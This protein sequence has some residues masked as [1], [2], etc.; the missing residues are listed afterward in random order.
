M[1][2]NKDLSLYRLQKAKK[3]LQAAQMLYYEDICDSSVN[4][5]YYAMFHALR[6]L[7]A[8]DGVD[9]KKHSAV[10]SY[11][12]KEYVKTGK[13]S[14][15]YSEIIGNAFNIRNSSDYEDFY[16]LSKIEVEE[17][18]VNAEKFIIAIEEYVNT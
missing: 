11:F 7:L 8:I 16:L 13:F 1:N 2:T 12:R 4:R 6:A 15:E 14:I 18:I 5:S 3:D 9:F 17:Q 10:I